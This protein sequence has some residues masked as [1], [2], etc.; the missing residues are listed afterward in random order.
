[1]SWTE[2]NATKQYVLSP[3]KIPDDSFYQ[4]CTALKCSKKLVFL[5][6]VLVHYMAIIV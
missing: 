2:H 4:Y 5:V 6:F 1:M 3:A